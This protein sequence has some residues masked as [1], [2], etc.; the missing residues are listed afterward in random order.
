MLSGTFHRQYWFRLITAVALAALFPVGALPQTQTPG[1]EAIANARRVRPLILNRTSY[2]LRAGKAVTI[3]APTQT[4]DFVRG[5]R[6]RRTR[7]GN[8]EQTGFVI[9]PGIRDD[10]ILLAASLTV[11]PG[12]YPVT[13]SA[14]NETGEEQTT[15]LNVTVEALQPV[16]STATRPP[17]VLLNGW[18][19]SCLL[20]KTAEGTFGTL[21]SSLYLDGAPVVYFFDNCV[22]GPNW[23]IEEL[24]N[25]LKQFL[26]L[27]RYDNG[28]QVQAV[29]FIAHSMGGLIVRS[30][31][32]GL[33]VDGSLVP[34]INVKVRKFIEIGTPN[35]G[36]YGAASAAASLLALDAQI[37]EMVPGST[38]LWTLATWNQR[39]DDLRGVDA[40]AIIGNGGYAPISNGSDGLVSVTSASLGFARDALR[41]RILP[42]CHSDGALS[43]LLAL[44]CS[45]QSIAKAPDS[46]AIIRSFLAGT[47]EWQSIGT[48]PPQDRWLSRYGGIYFADQTASGQWVSDLSSVSFGTVP[49]QSGGAT[50]TVFYNEF[51]S[52]T[53]TFHV[54]SSS[55]GA[56]NCGPLAEPPGLYTAWRCK[57]VPLISAVGPLFS[58]TPAKVVQSGTT[59][60]ISGIGFGQ[61]RCASCSVF[62]YPGPVPLQISSWADQTI[63][64]ALPSSY[65][66]LTWLVVQTAT[67]SDSIRFMAAPAPAI[68]LSQTQ[69]QF[70]YTV[71]SGTPAP[72]IITIGNGGG[73][74]LS[75]TA[76][77]TVGWLA[78]S[79]SS[80][81]TLT[82]SINPSGLGPGTYQGAISVTSTGATN[83][84]QTVSATLVVS[85][86]SNS[87]I[88]TSVTN[89]ASGAPGA[90]APGEIVTIKGSG[91]G[92]A[93]GA[94]FTVN[95]NTGM[96]D[97]TLAGTRVFFGGFAAPI[98]YASA[99]QINAIVPYEVA[100]QSQVT[101]QVE[102]QGTRSAGT[103]LQVATAAPGV[104]TLNATGSGQAIAANQDG[105]FN[106]P[107]APAPKGSYVT[108]YFTGGGLTD[109]PGVTGSVSG[110]TLKSL[111]QTAFVTVGGVAATVA[112]AGAA[113]TLVDGVGVLVVRLADNAASGLAQPL[114]VNVSGIISTSTATL[115]VQ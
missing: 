52:G 11:Q 62:A 95:P 37:P 102:Y 35:F 89:S 75:W 83:S 31:L 82:V 104:F 5:A 108:I 90:I 49:L 107:S 23:K 66:G 78:V 91:L 97:T 71:G 80:A 54:T 41:T 79:V 73:G 100:G 2:R 115:S 112:F 96:V 40:L 94:L 42:Y 33:Q 77:P 63:R 25:R 59:A 47:P 8:I 10:E 113:P 110:S 4:V 98:T 99:V 85:A 74:T 64:A 87:V 67:G 109:P 3:D 29:D 68:S 9:G 55:L 101:M 81:S 46:H 50:G 6:S 61:Q 19:S 88:V 21:E 106:G 32:V 93:V 1:A 65:N 44:D 114:V 15:V 103:T 105:S 12:E 76:T 30:Y 72:Q 48:P 16:A 43:Q 22:E 84:P 7:V 17:V 45:G 14:V 58:G 60:T 86:A 20:S 24:G 111:K 70:G 51:V 13:I 69:L 34:P 92:P 36:A 18:Q 27:I 26:D 39:S 57:S 38:F 28:N 56:L 53:D